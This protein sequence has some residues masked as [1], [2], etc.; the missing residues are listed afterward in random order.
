V[1]KKKDIQQL[2]AQRE[3]IANKHEGLKTQIDT[4]CSG[5]RR[6]CEVWLKRTKRHKLLCK[7]IIVAIDRRLADLRRPELA[8]AG[9]SMPGAPTVRI[10]DSRISA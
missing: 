8:Y 6:P 3:R 9:G 2:E 4:A 1:S 10:H 5:G 7:D